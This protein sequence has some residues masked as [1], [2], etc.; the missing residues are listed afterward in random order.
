MV[1]TPVTNWILCLLLEE[2]QF[3]QYANTC[4]RDVD[5]RRSCGMWCG[6]RADKG[7]EWSYLCYKKANL[8]LY[9]VFIIYYFK[10][11][12]VKVS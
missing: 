4:K 10:F 7:K 2:M 9:T 5:E 8:R 6:G 11:D 3:L 1:S 12:K